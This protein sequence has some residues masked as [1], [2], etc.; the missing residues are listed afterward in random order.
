MKL[1]NNE[2]RLAC[3]G[4]CAGTAGAGVLCAFIKALVEPHDTRLQIH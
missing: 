1:Q 4:I 2:I 3:L